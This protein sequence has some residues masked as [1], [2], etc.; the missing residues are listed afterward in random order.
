MN[1]TTLKE[2]KTL[3]KNNIERLKKMIEGLN[4]ITNSAQKFSNETLLLQYNNKY[5]NNEVYELIPKDNKFIEK[6]EHLQPILNHVKKGYSLG[7]KKNESDNKLVITKYLLNDDKCILLPVYNYIKNYNPTIF[8]RSVRSTGK[9]MG[10]TLIEEKES[11]ED[12]AYINEAITECEAKEE[13]ERKKEQEQKEAEKAKAER[14]KQKNKL[15][16]ETK[17]E[18]KIYNKDCCNNACDKKYPQITNNAKYKTIKKF[19]RSVKLK[20]CKVRCRNFKKYR[21]NLKCSG[22]SRKSRKKKKHTFS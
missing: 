17:T 9:A 5:E 6:I 10:T 7:N 20:T 1:T 21:V 12:K 13:A 19:T 22:G 2:S 8:E 15:E 3:L 11:K 4:K 14:K 16:I 18:E